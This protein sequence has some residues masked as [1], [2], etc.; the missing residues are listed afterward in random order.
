MERAI[1]EVEKG[2]QGCIHGHKT[3]QRMVYEGT[4]INGD[5]CVSALVSIF[6]ILYTL[7]NRGDLSYADEYGKVRVY[8]P[9]I[10]NLVV[11][12]CWREVEKKEV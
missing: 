6:P 12:N 10:D 4:R 2:N 1:I 11:F 8:C 9:D 3:G 5:I 7:K